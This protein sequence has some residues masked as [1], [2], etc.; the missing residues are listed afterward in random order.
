MRRRELHDVPR[1]VDGEPAVV[2]SGS[3]L[4]ESSLPRGVLP[5]TP[6]LRYNEPGARHRALSCRRARARGPAAVRGTA[7]RAV[8]G[9][10]ATAVMDAEYD[11]MCY[12]FAHLHNERFGDYPDTGSGSSRGSG[13]TPDGW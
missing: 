3:P 8:L 1:P 10:A 5:G 11:G 7:A 9:D 6:M 2:R 12:Y 13:G 4:A